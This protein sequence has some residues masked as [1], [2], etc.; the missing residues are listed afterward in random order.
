MRFRFKFANSLLPYNEKT[1][2]DPYGEGGIFVSMSVLFMLIKI[3][4]EIIFRVVKN[5]G[6]R[7]S[8]VGKLAKSRE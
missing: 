4:N 1:S 2:N 5:Y 7:G 3:R 6:W 8:A